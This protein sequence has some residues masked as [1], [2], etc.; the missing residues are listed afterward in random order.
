[1]LPV[2]TI[3]Q[4]T[5]AI[6]Y[7]KIKLIAVNC[8]TML[9]DTQREVVWDRNMRHLAFLLFNH[10]FDLA[11]LQATVFGSLL[12]MEKRSL[13]LEESNDNC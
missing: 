4:L 1:M 12:Q 6:D 8:S 2:V 10:G 13:Y 11:L 3:L 9:V 7:I 5:N